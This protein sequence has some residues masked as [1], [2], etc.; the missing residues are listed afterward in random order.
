MAKAVGRSRAAIAVRQYSIY[1]R[2]AY[3]VLTLCQSNQLFRNGLGKGLAVQ[4]VKECVDAAV[5]IFSDS[6]LLRL[7]Y[8]RDDVRE[9]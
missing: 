8:Y 7:R 1:T 6:S 9:L 2:I 5:E 3:E 4:G